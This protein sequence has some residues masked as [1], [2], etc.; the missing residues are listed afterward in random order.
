MAAKKRSPLEDEVI[1]RSFAV[2]RRNHHAFKTEC[3]RLGITMEV[4]INEAL[5][6]WLRT[7]ATKGKKKSS[8]K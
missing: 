6:H 4:G 7:N 3:A 8:K 5:E 2:R 1:R